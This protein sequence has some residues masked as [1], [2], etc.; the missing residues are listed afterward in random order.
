MRVFRRRMTKK[1]L[2]NFYRA[3][4]FPGRP[5]PPPPPLRLA[6]GLPGYQADLDLSLSVSR[7]AVGGARTLAAAMRNR[8]VS[9]SM[10]SRWSSPP[11]S[12]H[13]FTLS[14][15]PPCGFMN[16]YSVIA[17]DIIGPTCKAYIQAGLRQVEAL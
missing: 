17:E 2:R 13:T 5:S 12:S 15:A 1:C 9:H 3:K 8:P 4:F 10:K 11:S 14:L 7:A 16:S 6:R